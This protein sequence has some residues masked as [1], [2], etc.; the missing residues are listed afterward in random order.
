L[1][2]IRDCQSRWPVENH[3]KLPFWKQAKMEEIA[4]GLMAEDRLVMENYN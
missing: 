4:G 1:A 3:E 2:S